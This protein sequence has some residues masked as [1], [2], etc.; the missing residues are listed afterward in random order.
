MQTTKI[1]SGEIS[2]FLFIKPIKKQQY[3]KQTE[4]VFNVFLYFIFAIL[5]NK[6]NNIIT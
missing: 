6:T 3:L 2:N 5:K 4:T 1:N